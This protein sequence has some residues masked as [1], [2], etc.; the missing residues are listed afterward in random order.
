VICFDL[1]K[2]IR[3]QHA[4]LVYDDAYDSMEVS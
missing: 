1:A 4:D 3:T 2:Q